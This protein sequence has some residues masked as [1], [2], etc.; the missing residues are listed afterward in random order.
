M[1]LGARQQRTFAAS[2]IALDASR[3]L[4]AVCVVNRQNLVL[5]RKDWRSSTFS[6]REGSSKFFAVYGSAVLLPVSAL[7]NEAMASWYRKL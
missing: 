1:V 6:F 5:S 3:S 4:S 7:L 2:A